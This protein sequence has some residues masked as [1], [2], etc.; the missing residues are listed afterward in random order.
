MGREQKR[1]EQFQ[2]LQECHGK[3]WSTVTR[4]CFTNFYTGG[5]EDCQTQLPEESVDTFAVSAHVFVE[6]LQSMK[7]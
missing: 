6:A 5:L 1:W 7:H 4:S 3:N 2:F